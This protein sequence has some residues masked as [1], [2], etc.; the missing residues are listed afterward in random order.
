MKVKMLSLSVVVIASVSVAAMPDR[1][2]ENVARYKD[3]CRAYLKQDVKGMYRSPAGVLKHPFIVPGAAY[4]LQLWDWDS[5][6]AGI[7][8]ERLIPGEAVDA[9]RELQ[10]HLRGCVLNFLDYAGDGGRVPICLMPAG[11]PFWAHPEATGITANMHKPCLAQQAEHIVRAYG[12]EA[13]WLKEG[14]SALQAFVNRYLNHYRHR[15]T[16]LCFWMNDEA[17]GVDNDPATFYRP[18]RSSGSIYLNC[19]MYAE[20]QSMVYLSDRLGKPE[21]GRYYAQEAEA[22]GQAIRR[23][24]WDPRD[25]FYYSVDLGL[26]PRSEDAQGL[27]SGQPRSYDCLIQRLDVWSGFLALWS[28]VATPDQAREMVER[29][30]RDRRRFNAPAGIRTLSPL[31]KMYDLRASGNPSPWLGPVW[32]V[33]NWMTFRGLVRYGFMEDARELAEKTVLLFGHDLEANGSLHECYMPESGE[34]VL[35][36]GFQGWNFLV[37]DMIEWLDGAQR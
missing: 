30:Y 2:P 31:E 34:P 35:N 8:L 3:I 18:N 15:E 10:S 7:A 14:F 24:C 20:L 23:H 36:P 1:T 26:L 13:A 12:G 19:L 32:G 9:R 28:G 29:H 16:G 33:A 17:I 21:V 22:L 6:L 27:H 11:V 25:G 5:W 37:I 4:D